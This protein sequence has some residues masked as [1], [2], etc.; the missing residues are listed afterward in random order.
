MSLLYPQ[1]IPDLPKTR[2]FIVLWMRSV[3]FSFAMGHT[4]KVQ[5]SNF[6]VWGSYFFTQVQVS[7]D[8]FS[9]NRWHHHI[10]TAF[11]IYRGYLCLLFKF[12]WWSV[13]FKSD[14]IYKIL[15]KNLKSGTT[16]ILFHG[17]TDSHPGHIW[18]SMLSFNQNLHLKLFLVFLNM[19]Q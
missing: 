9:H 2:S 12:V 16:Q 1:V 10:K 15:K 7:L 5:C 6:P 8:N 4:G 14:N 17:S 11:C 13:T 3:T 18:Q 19:K